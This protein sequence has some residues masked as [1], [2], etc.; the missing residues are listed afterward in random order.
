MKLEQVNG[1]PIR[2]LQMFLN[3]VVMITIKTVKSQ[4][5]FMPLFRI[6][7]FAVTGKTAAELI[8]ER[9]DSEKPA[10]GLT[11]WKEAPNG[12]VLKRDIG[13]AK[14]YLNEKELSRL[15]R[16]VTMFIDYAELM[17]EDEILMSMQ[18]GLSRQI[19]F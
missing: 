19:S 14:N 1:E 3:S 7:C 6:N 13:I 11:T 8:Y 10:M 2:K 17:A 15:N 16:L 5:I 12:K 18:V 9:A 4:R